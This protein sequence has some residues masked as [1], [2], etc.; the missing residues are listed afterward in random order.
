[1][2][3]NSSYN[4]LS[5]S[6]SNSSAATDRLTSLA[7]SIAVSK[8][9]QLQ[10]QE[11]KL[12]I[13]YEEYKSSI[14][15]YNTIRVDFERKL[16]DSCNHFQYAEETHLKQMRVFVDSYSKLISNL[17]INR[18]QIFNEFQSKFEQFT[19]DYLLQV[20]IENK[21]TGTERPDVAQFIDQYDYAKLL[22]TNTNPIQQS[23]QISSP[24]SN[25][26]YLINEAEFNL[27]INGGSMFTNT[28]LNSSLNVAPQPISS[29]NM[30]IFSQ[31]FSPNSAD[32]SANNDFSLFSSN[33]NT[34]NNN[35]NN[36]NSNSRGTPVFFAPANLMNSSTGGQYSQLTNASS[37]TTLNSIAATNGT[38]N[39][40]TNLG[41]AIA[42]SSPT[43]ITSPNN[44]DNMKRSDSKGI[45][46]FN[47]D[48]LGRNK[49]KNVR[50]INKNK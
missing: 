31:Q 26:N 40:G 18:L 28:T 46:I 22:L 11:K 16:A 27:V 29:Q 37:I 24:N 41:N 32:N 19:S 36:N 3:H 2:T 12:K 20:F 5:S 14:E 45:N 10:K 6:G 35:N 13:A 30:P 38:G 17:N 47:V 7:S 21:R 44:T 9:S 43:N 25:N 15:K 39:N 33:S 4:G 23:S 49:K 50:K 8:V 48:F 1:M 34:N 42:A